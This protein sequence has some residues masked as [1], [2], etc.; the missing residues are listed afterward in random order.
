MNSQPGFQKTLKRASAACRKWRSNQD[1]AENL[2]RAH[3]KNNANIRIWADFFFKLGQCC[4][5]VAQ[6]RRERHFL[7]ARGS[8]FWEIFFAEN[9][10]QKTPL[11]DDLRFFETLVLKGRPKGRVCRAEYSKV[12]R[13]V[14][15]SEP[16]TRPE[17]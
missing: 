10:V 14:E 3:R 13:K 6:I 15:Y 9:F 11:A 7:G 1:F 12:G 5:K 17:D 2:R 8:I 16:S 4:L